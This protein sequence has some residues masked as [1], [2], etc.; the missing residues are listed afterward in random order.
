MRYFWLIL[1]ATIGFACGTTSTAV[2]GPNNRTALVIEGPSEADCLEEAHKECPYGYDI[3][4]NNSHVMGAVN[5]GSGTIGT[6]LGMLV[7]CRSKPVDDVTSSRPSVPASRT[8]DPCDGA[9]DT[10]DDFAKYWAE[11][12]KTD[13]TASP[14]KKADFTRV[15]ESF[16]WLIRRCIDDEYRRTHSDCS[17]AFGRLNAETRGKLDSLFLAPSDTEGKAAQ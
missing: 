12:E 6:S 10:F 2:V 3:L 1:L 11:Q 13:T 7:Q 8:T 9:Y 17:F 16:P 14:P 5:H 4:T 15:C